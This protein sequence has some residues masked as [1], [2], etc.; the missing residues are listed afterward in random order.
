MTTVWDGHE[1]ERHEHVLPD[2]IGDGL[3]DGAI[4]RCDG[5]RFYFIRREV[6]SGFGSDT[7]WLPLRWWHWRARRRIAAWE[8]SHP[9][10]NYPPRPEETH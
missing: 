8:R 1:E 2:P 3:V 4:A 7:I 6:Y 5:C 10:R 9:W